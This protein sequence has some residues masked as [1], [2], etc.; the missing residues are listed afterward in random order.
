MMQEKLQFALIGVIV[1]FVTNKLYDIAA[2]SIERRRIKQGLVHELEAV[3]FY[4]NEFIKLCETKFDQ[5]DSYHDGDFP[6]KLTTPISDK[7][8]ADICLYLNSSQRTSFNNIHVMID[9]LNNFIDAFFWQ[10]CKSGTCQDSC[11]L[12]LAKHYAASTD[13]LFF[14]KNHVIYHRYPIINSQI[15]AELDKS[16]GKVY[17]YLGKKGLTLA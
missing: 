10:P 11:K 2:V 16:R 5:V 14:V 4:L 15:D 3:S 6:R 9:E 13:L 1:G 7:Y 12:N 17:E 8:Y